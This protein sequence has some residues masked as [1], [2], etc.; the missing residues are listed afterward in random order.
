MR[1]RWRWPVV[2]TVAASSLLAVEVATRCLTTSTPHGMPVFRGHALLPLRPSESNVDSWLEEVESLRYV[3]TDTELGWTIVA[4][5]PGS[6]LDSNVQ[7]IR[8]G[9]ERV[10]AARKPENVHRVLAFG[11]SFVHGDEV[12]VAECW[13]VV[14]ES[15]ANDLEVLNFGVPG[16]GT[17]QALLRWRRDGQG[18]ECDVVVLGIWPED[19]CR[20]LNALRYFLVSTGSFAPKPLFVRHGEDLVLRNA[21]DFERSELIDALAGGTENRLIEHEFWRFEHELA[22]PWW[23]GSRALRVAATIRSVLQRRDL[24]QRF[25]ED[26]DPRANDRTVAI[27]RLLASEVKVSGARLLVVLLPMYELL[28]EFPGQPPLPLVTRL[29]S[30]G[31]E[32]LDL[33]ATFER[34][35]EEGG[36]DRAFLPSG[37]YSAAGNRMVAQELCAW[38]DRELPQRTQ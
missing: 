6:G 9:S 15:M 33:S 7:G 3:V 24:R 36:R 34:D 38:V 5:A 25:Y 20:N 1:F 26:E 32:V 11:D 37:H 29:R 19:V 17:D 22:D 16:Y 28:E 8:C 27:A 13:P 4:G 14:A 35:V 18:F 12:P 31:I 10:Y 21:C 2:C 23:Y 30:Q